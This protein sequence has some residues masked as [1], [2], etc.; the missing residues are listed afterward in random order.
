VDG[1][2]FDRIA[3][4]WAT[5]TNRR[6]ALKLV[7]VGFLVAWWPS[8]R[9]DSTAQELPEPTPC[10]QDAEC[11]DSDADACTGTACVD[12]LCTYFIVDCIP[13]HICCGN[14][15]CCP[16]EESAS[17]IADT[18]CVAASDDPCAGA[19][20]EGGSCVPFLATCD[21]DFVCCGN[22]DC[23]PVGNGC[24]AD[25]DCSSFPSVLGGAARCISGVCVPGTTP[26]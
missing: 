8:A 10:S 24:V 5:S 2:Q 19:R 3:R 12:G 16:V 17:C 11:L 6:R 14:G 21:P 7:G 18:D 22:G 26:A 13:G 1:G 15:T 20:C 25:A 23:C 9:R 4:T